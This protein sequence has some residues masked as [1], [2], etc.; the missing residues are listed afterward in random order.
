M[1]KC[2]SMSEYLKS[3]KTITDF[4]VDGKCSGCGS[5]CSDLLPLTKSDIKRV[6]QYMKRHHIELTPSKKEADMDLT[7]PF[8]ADDKR[9]KVYAA[10]PMI[11]RTFICNK[12]PSINQGTVEWMRSATKLSMRAVFGNDRRN[13]ILLQ[14]IDFLAKMAGEPMPF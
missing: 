12:K 13:A 10:R 4:T 3:K 8:L 2:T 11:C 5:C 9:C 6:K 14:Y 7:C 1:F